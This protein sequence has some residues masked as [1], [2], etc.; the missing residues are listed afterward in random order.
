MTE[1][2]AYEF[3][4]KL[5]EK[6]KG[7]REKTNRNTI[8]SLIA[9]IDNNFITGCLKKYVGTSDIL[10]LAELSSTTLKNLVDVVFSDT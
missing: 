6:F 3:V 5:L 8:I 7:T 4:C 1:Q 9:D 10:A 2:E